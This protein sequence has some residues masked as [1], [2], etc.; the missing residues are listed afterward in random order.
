MRGSHVI[1]RSAKTQQG[2]RSEIRDPLSVTAKLPL[3][4]ED[5]LL[6]RVQLLH[7]PGEGM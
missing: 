7:Q 4:R 6:L 3:L 5:K 1:D 2:L